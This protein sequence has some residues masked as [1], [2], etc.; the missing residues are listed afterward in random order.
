MTTA[1]AVTKSEPRTRGKVPNRLSLGYHR[2]PKR[3]PREVSQ[4]AGAPSLSRKRKINATKK[5]AERPA[6]RI[7]VSVINS[8]ERDGGA[9]DRI[10]SSFHDNR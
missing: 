4:K 1:P 2:W 7:K 8:R 5:M 10:D 3:L 9:W 6:I